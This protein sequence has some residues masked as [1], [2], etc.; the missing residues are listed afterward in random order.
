MHIPATDTPSFH[1]CSLSGDPKIVVRLYTRSSRAVEEQVVR[2]SAC[3]V[4]HSCHSRIES[5]NSLAEPSA[6]S[7]G[8]V[9]REM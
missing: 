6:K 5:A 3:D 7:E 8:I 9:G 1:G 4:D 2:V